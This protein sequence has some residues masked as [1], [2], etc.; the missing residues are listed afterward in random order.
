MKDTTARLQKVQLKIFIELERIINKYDLTYFFVCVSMLGAKRH[1]GFIPW[2]DDLDVGMPRDDYDK[3]LNVL[4]TELPQEIKLQTPYN[5]RYSAVL[6]AKLRLQGTKFIEASNKKSR[7]KFNQIFIDI[8]PYDGCG[9][10][11][12]KARKHA[13]KLI[14]YRKLINNSIYRGRFIT[15]GFRKRVFQILG[16]FITIFINPHYL[17]RKYNKLTKRYSF[18]ESKYVINSHT[19]M[20]EFLSKEV[21]VKKDAD[22]NFIFEGITIN[23]VANPEAYLTSFYGDWRKLPEE[24]KRGNYHNIIELDFGNHE[25]KEDKLWI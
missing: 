4:P 20:K 24:S 12:K 7:S 16:R 18:E 9:N 2:D 14:F 25:A 1:N 10:D 3:L 11:E 15:K 23:G 5:D 19:N 8:F 22:T 13:R 6:F 17:I 21:L